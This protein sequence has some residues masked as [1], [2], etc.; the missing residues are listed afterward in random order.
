MIF[1]PAADVLLLGSVMRRT[2]LA[3]LFVHHSRPAQRAR[4]P[5]GSDD[6]STSVCAAYGF[7]LT[8]LSAGRTGRRE[9]PTHTFVLPSPP[10]AASGSL[11]GSPRMFK[12]GHPRCRRQLFSET[13]CTPRGVES[14][15]R[16]V[17]TGFEGRDLGAE[18]PIRR[19]HVEVWSL[20]PGD[21]P[22][23]AGVMLFVSSPFFCLP[24][25]QLLFACRGRAVNGVLAA[26]FDSRGSCTR[27]PG[28][29]LDGPVPAGYG[30]ALGGKAAITSWP[31]AAYERRRLAGKIPVYSAYARV[32]RTAD[33]SLPRERSGCRV[34]A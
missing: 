16:H 2:E 3:V 6:P 29:E 15:R 5:W 9:H 24:P 33:A 1:L 7:A 11:H 27:G 18:G 10:P 25:D 20:P 26:G 13:F 28:I 34:T 8:F 32:P 30:P 12:C 23:R 21:E 31:P 4:L 14:T 19:V 22:V 17:F